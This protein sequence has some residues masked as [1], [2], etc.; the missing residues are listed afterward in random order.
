MQKELA[1]YIC[2]HQLQVK[3]IIEIDLLETLSDTNTYYSQI[4]L[5]V[6]ESVGTSPL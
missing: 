4:Q 6:S 1:H 5:L 3:M 2:E